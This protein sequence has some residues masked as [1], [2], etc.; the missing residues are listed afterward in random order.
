MK[1]KRII[2][3]LLAEKK[4]PVYIP[5]QKLEDEETNWLNKLS[6]VYQ[7][8][9]RKAELQREAEV[10]AGLSAYYEGRKAGE[11][12][13]A[14][15]PPQSGL[16]SNLWNAG[17]SAVGSVLSPTNAGGGGLLSVQDGDP[18]PPP[19][20]DRSWFE[21]QWDNFVA[22]WNEP[23]PWE[24]PVPAS[25]P[26]VDPT[27]VAAIQSGQ[28]QVYGTQTAQ[29]MPTATVTPSPTATSTPSPWYPLMNIPLFPGFPPNLPDGQIKDE[30]IKIYDDNTNLC[31]EIVLAM[32][33]AG[34]NGN[35][36]NLPVIYKNAKPYLVDGNNVLQNTGLYAPELLQI[37]LEDGSLPGTWSGTAYSWENSL[38]IDK[39]GVQLPLRNDVHYSEYED[40][41]VLRNLMMNGDSNIYIIPL[42]QLDPKNGYQLTITNDLKDNNSISHWVLVTGFSSQ[43]DTNNLMSPNNQVQIN[44][45]YNNSVETYPWSFFAGSM[46]TTPYSQPAIVILKNESDVP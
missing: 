42:V 7:Y 6:P 26:T 30:F 13:T 3:A 36:D 14:S 22:W 23:W 10:Q 35:Q 18:P 24:K 21:E 19:D 15:T 20:G 11:E 28:T 37:A 44:N 2:G 31:G 32:I 38:D 5:S 17:M 45:P 29:A 34:L 4:D 1:Q 8:E 16:L 27:R 41:N 40:G 9:K 12:E 43:W 39:F 33:A 46:Q 25:T